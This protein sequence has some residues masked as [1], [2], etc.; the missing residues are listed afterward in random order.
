[1]SDAEF[2]ELIKK[3]E[4]IVRRAD[5]IKELYPN[6]KLQQSELAERTSIAPG[7]LSNYIRS[8]EEEN[9]LTV[10]KDVNERGQSVNI[11]GLKDFTYETIKLASKR[12][13]ASASKPVL[14]DRETFNRMLQR[15][16]D[17]DLQDFAKDAIQT[18]T[19]EYSIPNYMDYF[20]FL[21][22]NLRNS[23]LRGTL[24]I[25][26]VS[27]RNIVRGLTTQEKNEIIRAIGEELQSILEDNSIK[28]RKEVED[29]LDELGVYDIPFNKLSSQYLAKIK[30]GGDPSFLRSLILR[31]PREQRMNLWSSM[32]DLHETSDQKVRSIIQKELPLLL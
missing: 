19:Q 32:M 21:K 2:D 13:Q 22:E 25:L 6:I 10:K 18:L 26:L 1:M 24:R 17:P 9:I 12:A 11:I 8:L 29:L 14:K 30:E 3:L 28:F 27:A 15:L 16:F 4:L 23:E 31:N 5:I 20:H 7:N